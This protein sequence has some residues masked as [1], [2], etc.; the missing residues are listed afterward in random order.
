M[1]NWSRTTPLVAILPFVA[2]AG[3]VQTANAQPMYA[4]ANIDADLGAP[5]LSDV[6]DINENGDAVGS[7]FV[8]GGF[9]PF[10]YNF[11]HGGR[12]LPLIGTNPEAVPVAVSD[13]DANGDIL[14]AATVGELG[15]DVV[16]TGASMAYYRVSTT[17]GQVI[18]SVEIPELPGFAQ[19]FAADINN[20]GKIVGYS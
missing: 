14:I 12:F 1:I 11:E 7:A 3:F 15:L 5:G 19:A 17:T 9:L 16:W 6:T 10:V 4:V 8:G 13:R 18:E 20:A 2:L